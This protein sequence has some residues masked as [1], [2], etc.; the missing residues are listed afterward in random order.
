[1]LADVI[2]RVLQPLLN[3]ALPTTPTFTDG[4]KDYWLSDTEDFKDRSFKEV[5]EAALYTSQGMF[6]DIQFEAERELYRRLMD[7]YPPPEWARVK[8]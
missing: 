5:A 7:L 3:D 4:R 8:E 6:G 1:M 2:R